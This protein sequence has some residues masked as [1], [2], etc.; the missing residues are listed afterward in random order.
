MPR[1]TSRG[2]RDQLEDREIG[3]DRIGPDFGGERWMGLD[4]NPKKW[5]IFTDAEVWR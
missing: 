3:S 4:R 5:A 2:V 1:L